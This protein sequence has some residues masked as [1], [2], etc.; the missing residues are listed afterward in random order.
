MSE[1]SKIHLSAAPVNQCLRESSFGR[2]TSCK[3]IQL[4]RHSEVTVVVL[5]ALL[6]PSSSVC[7]DSSL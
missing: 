3:N 5:P 1:K 2:I 4:N 7:G 6:V